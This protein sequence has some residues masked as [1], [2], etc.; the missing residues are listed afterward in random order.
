M[1][2]MVFVEAR[3]VSAMNVVPCEKLLPEIPAAA[4]EQRATGL[5]GECTDY[6]E[7]AIA[8]RDPAFRPMDGTLSEAQT[9]DVVPADV[10][11]AL[12]RSLEQLGMTPA[13]AALVASL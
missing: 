1:Q 5:G 8:E 13:R 4:D 2:A 9:V 10:R 3:T 11:L 12:A 7:E 6:S